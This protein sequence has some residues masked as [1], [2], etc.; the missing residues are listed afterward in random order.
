MKKNY[1]LI[2][3]SILIFVGCKSD[4]D[5][6]VGLQIQ[7]RPDTVQV[8]QNSFIEID[9][10]SND[11]NI[12]KIGTLTVTNS[13]YANIIILNN[14][15]PTDPS[16]DKIIYTPTT[17]YLG[18][19]S[20]VYTICSSELQCATGTVTV[21]ILPASP[22]IYNPDAL[23]Y[24]KLSDYNFFEGDLKNLNPV[25]GVIPYDLNST[26]FSDYARK[27]R[28]VWMPNGSK[29]TYNSDYTPLDFPIGAFLIKNFYYEN[30]LPNN[31]TQIIE[32]RLMYFTESGW[33]FAE[34]VWNADQTDA[35]F[36]IDGSFVP[37]DWDEAGTTKS[38]NYRV[39]SRA[40][41]FTCHNKFGTPVPIGPKP[42]NL[43]KNYS[44][45]EGTTNQLE[46]WVNS[47]YLD[48]D[49]P[50][51]IES[52]VAWDDTLQPL[53]LRARSYFDI[54]CAHCHSEE[55]YCE[56]RPMRFAFHESEI[57]SNM[58]IC[59]QPDTNLGSAYPLTVNPGNAAGSVVMF[60]M[61]SIEEQYRMPVLGRTL[62]HT[63]G[64]ALI[65][66]WINGLTD[67]CN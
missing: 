52:T 63:E 38:V 40:E 28:F 20:F 19:D 45:P 4:D 46:K 25:S 47:G 66:E 41:C 10:F 15:T 60:R 50:E 32:T 54:N 1:F 49:Y 64:I 13:I 26:L 16:D 3:L 8:F 37:L 21:T 33:E 36:T 51:I 6:Y 2:F 53:D 11:S 29:A 31:T 27:K 62:Q 65:T 43:N 22:V 23:P 42:Q 17:D 7:T 48:S 55:S 44:Y 14:G 57:P 58:G 18:T 39:P 67:R 12:P 5:A 24:P 59:V 9:V 35:S 30:V 56:Y 34:Y 61:S